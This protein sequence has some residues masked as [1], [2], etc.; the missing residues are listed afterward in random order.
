LLLLLVI[1]LDDRRPVTLFSDIALWLPRI[2][3][4]VK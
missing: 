2:A 4:L 3:G 1:V